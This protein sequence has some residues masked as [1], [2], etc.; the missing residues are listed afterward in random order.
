MD[1]RFSLTARDDTMVMR[2]SPPVDNFTI[3]A[4]VQA[5]EEHEI[6]S[7]A[8]QLSKIRDAGLPLMV[9]GWHR[10]LGFFGLGEGIFGWLLAGQTLTLIFRMLS[11]LPLYYIGKHLV[12]GRYA[13]LS[14][15]YPGLSALAGGM[16]D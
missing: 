11:L 6:E 14:L 13:F 16:G 4:W 8:L 12:G 3:S 5:A 1:M 2:Y 10:V 15:F 9:Y 7:M